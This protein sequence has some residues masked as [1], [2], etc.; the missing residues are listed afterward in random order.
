M[1]GTIVALALMW[2][3]RA[4]FPSGQDI[5]APREL[6]SESLS[7][8][9]QYLG[10]GILNLEWSHE[11]RRRSATN[12]VKSGKEFQDLISHIASEVTEEGL[13]K[14]I[15][16]TYKHTFPNSNKVIADVLINKGFKRV[17]QSMSRTLPA[18][19]NKL[20]A[21][22]GASLVITIVDDVFVIDRVPTKLES[23]NDGSEVRGRLGKEVRLPEKHL[24]EPKPSRWVW[25]WSVWEWFWWYIYPIF[26][27]GF[28]L[29]GCML[30]CLRAGKWILYGS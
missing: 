25:V 11:E 18:F 16:K 24:G 23:H 6:G 1:L 21:K 12:E 5:N 4:A 3:D 17:A 13:E 7:F 20:A 2:T 27:A 28:L 10:I 19:V 14:V 30:I 29:V 15:G 26:P 8:M 9:P 22:S